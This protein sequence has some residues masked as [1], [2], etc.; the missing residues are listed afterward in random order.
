MARPSIFDN[1]ELYNRMLREFP[2]L[3]LEMNDAQERFIRVK[4]RFGNTPKR[5]LFEGGNKI[6]KTWIGLAEDIAYSVGYRCWLP[7]DD[8]DHKVDIKVPNI[9]LIGCETMMHS[10]AEKIE[11]MLKQLIPKTCQPVFKPGPTGILIRVKLPFGIYGEKCGSEIHVRSY[12]Q[13]P[14]TF[15]GIDF[16]Y[17]HYDEPPPNPIYTAVERGKVVTNASSW[18]TM[19][20]LKEPWVYDQLSMK[21]ATIV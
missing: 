1:P 10:V 8:P 7:P 20:P 12:D 17:V 2:L 4:N 19:T 21:A 6:G 5:R 16:E 14:D 18:L 11:P 13:R 9:G 3:F 15:E